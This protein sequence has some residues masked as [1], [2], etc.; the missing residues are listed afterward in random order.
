[1]FAI[2]ADKL[3][4]EGYRLDTQV[5]R[6]RFSQSYLRQLATAYGLAETMFED[7]ETYPA[8]KM[9]LCVFRK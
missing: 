9:W 2:T 5:G 8:Y 3:E 1:L 4:G 7:A 6:F